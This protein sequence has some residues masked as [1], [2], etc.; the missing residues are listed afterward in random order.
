MAQAGEAARSGTMADCHATDPKLP[1]DWL[2]PNADDVCISIMLS[3]AAYC[4]PRDTNCNVIAPLNCTIHNTKWSGILAPNPRVFM[5]K[6]SHIIPVCDAEKVLGCP[7]GY[8]CLYPF[9][10]NVPEGMCRIY[11]NWT[12]TPN[13]DSAT[14][15][16]GIVTLSTPLPTGTISLNP[17]TSTP[18]SND[19]GAQG[20]HAGHTDTS[21]IVGATLGAAVGIIAIVLA[22]M[23]YLRYMRKSARQET[24]NDE[25]G[26]DGQE[27][28]EYWSFDGRKDAA[29]RSLSRWSTS[30][31]NQTPPARAAQNQTSQATESHMAELA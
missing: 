1:T 21:V 12:I 27:N 8:H 11:G 25:A 28:T 20:K 30:T 16:S 31:L 7:Y 4:C 9:I 26:G 29:G 17:S 13:K 14:E 2:C 15:A 6:P 10:N 22:V 18:T 24:A 5:R 23:V 3:D 19:A